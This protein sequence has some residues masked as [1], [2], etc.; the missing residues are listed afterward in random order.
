[1]PTGIIAFFIVLAA[2]AT[3]VMLVRGVVIMGRGSDPTGARSQ[4]LMRARVKWQ[5]I[6][7]VLVV[8]ALLLFQGAS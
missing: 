5:A 4:Q 2:L 6:T 3:L 8:V 1:M 7:I